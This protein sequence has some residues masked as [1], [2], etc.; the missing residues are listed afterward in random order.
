M[1]TSGLPSAST[2]STDTRTGCRKKIATT[3][4]RSPKNILRVV[5]SRCGTQRP[6][7]EPFKI[8]A[9][10]TMSLQQP[11]I[12]ATAAR[13]LSGMRPTARSIVIGVASRPAISLS[14]FTASCQLSPFL[15]L[16]PHNTRR[17]PAGIWPQAIKLCFTLLYSVLICRSRLTRQLTLLYSAWLGTN[18]VLTR[19]K[20]P[21]RQKIGARG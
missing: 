14:L 17:E 9:R 3:A 11:L 18:L 13:P 15:Y 19:E 6:F 20:K 4:L 10:L 12:Y 8:L 16:L 5:L 2:S 7:F 1:N 21:L